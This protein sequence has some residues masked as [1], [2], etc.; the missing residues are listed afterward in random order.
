MTKNHPREANYQ[1]LLATA[2]RIDWRLDDVLSPT[3]TFDFSRP[4]LP[5]ALAAT[6]ALTFLDAREQLVL[7]RSART[8]TSACSVKPGA[9]RIRYVV[10]IKGNAAREVFEEIHREMTMTSPNRWHVTQPIVLEPTL[11]VE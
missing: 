4:F 9:E 5:D 3:A 8:P 6:S 2:E 1:H 10:R 11:V 7:N